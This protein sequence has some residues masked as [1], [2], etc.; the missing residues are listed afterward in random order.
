MNA[1]RRLDALER[2]A[3]TRRQAQTAPLRFYRRR[4]DGWI[5]LDGRDGPGEWAASLDDLPPEQQPG[6]DPAGA[7]TFVIIDPVTRAP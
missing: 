5:A 1:Q 6:A 7:A 4:E 3:G 2:A